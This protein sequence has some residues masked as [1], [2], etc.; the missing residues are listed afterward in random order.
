MANSETL[1]TVYD[2]IADYIQHEGISPSQREIAEGCFITPPTVLRY[3]DLLEAQN[4]I[5]RIRGV[6]RSIHLVQSLHSSA[7]S[8]GA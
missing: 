3:L 7:P 8:K 4:R 2:F 1:E 6:A 5:H